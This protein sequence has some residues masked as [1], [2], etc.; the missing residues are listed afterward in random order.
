MI[1]QAI[2][3][4]GSDVEAKTICSCGCDLT[5]RAAEESLKAGFTVY[6]ESLINESVPR[7]RVV[8]LRCSKCLSLIVLVGEEPVVC[9]KK[10]LFCSACGALLSFDP[11]TDQGRLRRCNM[12]DYSRE[13]SR[14]RVQCGACGVTNLF[15]EELNYADKH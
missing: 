9:E 4:H 2:I 11:D 3:P 6:R 12:S 15:K 10:T 8:F 5:K 7:D 14:V 1:E 13:C